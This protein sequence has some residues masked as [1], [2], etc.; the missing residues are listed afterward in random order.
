MAEW[1]RFFTEA[2]AQ[3]S[4]VVLDAR[5]NSETTHV[6]NVSRPVGVTRQPLPS[7]FRTACLRLMQGCCVTNFS[8][9]NGM[10]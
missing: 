8:S 6:Y 5:D 4:I 9:F 3:G 1:S 2:D 10:V 7:R